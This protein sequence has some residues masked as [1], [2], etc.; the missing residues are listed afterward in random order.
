MSRSAAMSN[1]VRR[2]GEGSGKRAARNFREFDS[3]SGG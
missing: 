3:E 2:L 1:N